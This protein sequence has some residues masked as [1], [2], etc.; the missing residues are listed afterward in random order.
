MEAD[1]VRRD[2]KGVYTDDSGGEATPR[3]SRSIQN[4]PRSVTGT[5]NGSDGRSALASPLSA[6]GGVFTDSPDIPTELDQ[7]SD[8]GTDAEGSVSD[9]DGDLHPGD[10]E[11]VRDLLDI[12]ESDY[13]P[14]LIAD[15]KS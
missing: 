4:T 6:D 8:W 9:I 1:R 13:R 11:V 2:L 3:R 10:Q 5:G 15:E 7:R 14:P 12:W